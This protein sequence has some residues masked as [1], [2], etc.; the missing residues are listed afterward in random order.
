ML[1]LPKISGLSIVIMYLELL[2]SLWNAPVFFK[3]KSSTFQQCNSITW[4][5]LSIMIGQQHV[6]KCIAHAVCSLGAWVYNNKLHGQVSPNFWS[7]LRCL[8]PFH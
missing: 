3:D 8:S 1:R 5:Q 6:L 2:P 4:F 7:G